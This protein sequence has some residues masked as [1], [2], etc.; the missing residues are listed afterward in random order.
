MPRASS[1]NQ[2]VERSVGNSNAYEVIPEGVYI[3]VISELGWET[4]DTKSGYQMEKFTPKLRLLNENGTKI[5]RQDLTIG[6][7]NSDGNY[8]N[9]FFNNPDSSI[10][11]GGYNM[12]KGNFGARNFMFAAGMLNNNGDVVFNEQAIVDLVVRVRIKT[13]TY[14]WNNE[15]RHENVIVW[16]DAP[17]AED[18][19]FI[20]ENDIDTDEWVVYNLCVAEGGGD[21]I[22]QHSPLVF[23]TKQAFDIWWDTMFTNTD[24]W[25]HPT[26]ALGEDDE[27]TFFSTW[28]DWVYDDEEE[29][30][31]ESTDVAFGFNE[32]EVEP[33][34]ED[35]A[36]AV[37]EIDALV[38]AIADGDEDDEVAM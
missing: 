34:A 21:E 29:E 25:E 1:T 38:D 18:T 31:E 16:W 17:Q 7:I 9:E 14:T 15:T 6:A 27:N 5:D 10:I 32:E 8:T 33:E 28:N 30:V 22:P 26:G 24:E 35:N 11:F 4:F 19:D 20:L 37:D 12:A 36:E 3:G 2:S 23:S 13:R